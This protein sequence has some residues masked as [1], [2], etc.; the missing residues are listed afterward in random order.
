MQDT[1]SLAKRLNSHRQK[2]PRTNNNHITTSLLLQAA[3]TTTVDRDKQHNK[4][5]GLAPVAWTRS[6]RLGS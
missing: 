6:R 4:R 2:K 5:E 3:A 1:L